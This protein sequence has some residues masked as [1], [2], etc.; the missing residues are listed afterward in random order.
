MAAPNVVW[1]PLPGS[2]RTFLS[3]PYYEVLLEGNRGGGKTDALLMCF[4]Q[5]VGRGFGREWRGVIFRQT[6]PE[7]GDI[8][9][10]S[11][12]WFTQIFPGAKY[13]VS[14]LKW[15]FE[16]GEELLFRFGKEEAD[17]WSYHGHA[18]PFLG[19]EELTNWKD[20]SFY[21]AMLSTC[22][23]SDPRVPRWVRA[24]TNP[25][26]KG[27]S[28][29]KER[30][31]IG[32][33]P[34]CTPMGDGRKKRLYVHSSLMENTILT[35]ADPDYVTTLRNLKEPA[36][37]AAWLDGSWDISVGTYLEKVWDASS[38]VVD[39]FPIPAH[40]KVWKAMDWGYS[41]PYAVLWLA[42]SE[43][44]VFFVWRELY[45]ID[46]DQP[47]VGSKENALDVAA[48]IKRVQQHDERY[49][50]EYHMDLAD[51]AI[52]SKIG[53]SQSIGQIFR[54]AGVRWQPAWNG[55]GSRV[56][57]A[58]MIVSLLAEGRLKFFK[59]CTNCIRTI[60]QLPPSDFNPE[61]VDTD[62]EDHCWDSLRYGVMRRR[63]NPNKD[64]TESFT[65]ESKAE[66]R[67]GS[68]TFDPDD[69]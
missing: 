67:D 21:E 23:S 22:R 37:R 41:K 55:P 62:A 46:A 33:V 57:G 53:A 17:Y 5:M 8:I 15:M 44:G 38:C 16:T 20:F 42:L 4:A 45:G 13:N 43:E 58:Q 1:Q 54:G 30:F 2:Q 25:F 19:F 47:N 6:Y 40:W 36:R 59:T 48:K 32:T 51:P 52:F 18:Y 28:W 26:G 14:A 27:H 24:T 64:D 60:P 9:D 11:Q 63:R 61:D 35:T 7:L 10:K 34:P 39:P 66:V 3:C 68:I 69:F 31:Q 65:P 56:N 12:K 29:V 49:G 50:Y